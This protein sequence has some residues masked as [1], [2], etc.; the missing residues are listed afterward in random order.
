M[1]EDVRRAAP[2]ILD[3]AFAGD[4]E[5]PHLHAAH[6]FGPL[7]PLVTPGDV[8]A[9]T[10]RQ[11]VDLMLLGEQLDDVASVQFGAAV[12]LRAVAL[13]DDGQLHDCEDPGSPESLSERRGVS[14]IR[15]GAGRSDGVGSYG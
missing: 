3:V 14:K 11:H 8:V 6:R 13:D 15:C 5:A 7:G 9:R 1:L 12:D 2:E 4:A 10:G